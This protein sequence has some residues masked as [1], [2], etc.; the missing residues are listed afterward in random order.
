MMALALTMGM[1]SCDDDDDPKPEPTPT[2]K[3]QLKL[4][5]DTVKV[6][7]GETATFNILEGGG[8]YKVICENAE[9]ASA[10]VNG[11]AVTVSSSVKGLTGLVISDADGNYKRLIVKSMYFYMDL[12]KQAV[13]I[14]MKLGHTDGQAVV[15]VTAGNGNYS[16]TV[17]DESVAKVRSI[18]GDVITLQGVAMGQTTMTVTD[19]MGL[20]KTVNVTVE[21][22]TIPF[23]DDELE[24]LKASNSNVFS[25]DGS[26]SYSWGTFDVQTSGDKT[27]ARW[28]YYGYYQQS[29]TWTGDATV[30][31]KGKGSFSYKMSW[32]GTA[33][34]YEDVDVEI[35]KNDG[36]RI[37]GIASVVKDNY[38][39]CGNFCV[40]L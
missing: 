37:W 1:A 34:V 16:A 21:T 38:L 6:G 29:C 2:T 24:A 9:I 25:W 3:S 11:T 33:T 31:K 23:T 27:T 26:L 30:G 5:V 8:D 40:P 36:S 39:Y 18:S 4:D 12:D 15:T 14:G 13:S 35:I 20:T 32:G 28:D 10:T 17:A 22:T 19:M 7:V